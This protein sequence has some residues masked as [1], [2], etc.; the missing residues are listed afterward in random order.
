MSITKEEMSALDSI[1]NHG[2]KDDSKSQQIDPA[3]NPLP[4]P[5]PQVSAQQSPRRSFSTVYKVKILAAYEA[6]TNALS[7]GELLR[8]EGLY[9]SRISSWR[10]QRDAGR[11]GKKRASSSKPTHAQLLR[12]NGRLKKK[13]SQAEAIIDLQKKLSELL[14]QH[15]LPHEQSEVRS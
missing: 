1:D 4:I 6:C 13:L 2:V 5:D 7:R 10:K 12:E 15:I 3:S 14:G 8:K 11:L 9:M